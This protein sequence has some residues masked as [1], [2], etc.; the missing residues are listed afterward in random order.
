MSPITPAVAKRRL[1][2]LL[3]CAANPQGLRGGAYPSVMPVLEAAGLVTQRAEGRRATYWFLT[4]A[5][6]EALV[7]TGK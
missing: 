6:R 5:G 4:P 1:D 3:A 2:A 7:G